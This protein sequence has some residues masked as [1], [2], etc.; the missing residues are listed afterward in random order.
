MSVA[1]GLS[2]LAA[3]ATALASASPSAAAGDAAPLETPPA[4]A[5]ADGGTSIEYGTESPTIAALLQEQI[6]QN[7]QL[8]ANSQ[9]HLRWEGY[10]DFGFYVPQGNGAGY[11]QDYGHAIF[12]RAPYTNYSWVFLGDILAPAV[13]SRGEVADLGNAPGVS[14][15]DSIH[16][17][18]AAG[19][20]ANEINLRLHA[21]PVSNAI[22]TTSVN[23]TPRT[24]SNFSL[25]DSFDVDIAQLEWLPTESRRTSIFVGK[26]ESV[27]GIEYRDRKSDRRFGVTPSLIARYTTGTALGLKVRSKFGEDDWLIVAAALTNGSNTTEQFFFYDETDSNSGKTGSARVAI[28][29]PLPFR[30]ELGMSG[31]YGPQDRT[32]SN[33]HAMWFFGPDLLATIGPLDIKIQWLKGKAAGDPTQNV[34]QLDLKGGGYVEIDTMLTA[35]WGLLGRMEYRDAFIALDSNRAYVTQSWRATGGARLVL[36]SWAAIKAEYL[37]NGEYGQIPAIRNDVFTSSLVL[38]Y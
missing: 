4:T 31:S 33:A 25:G 2:C 23:F 13:N 7:E 8:A 9:S 30:L 20:V 28:R 11:V 36:N 26:F 14:R 10:I 29:P 17:R 19:F 32:T 34:Y 1:S 38:G 35:S 16:S 24:G 21:T 22:I 15:F 5:A 3:M 37:H 18:G 12:N 6:R 27:L